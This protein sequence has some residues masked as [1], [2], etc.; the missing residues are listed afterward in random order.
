M[1]ILTRKPG[2]VI[3]IKVPAAAID[4]AAVDDNAK[5]VMIEITI[6]EIRGQQARVGVKAPKSVP[7][8]RLEIFQRKLTS[9]IDQHIDQQQEPEHSDRKAHDEHYDDI[10]DIDDE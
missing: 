10:F 9:V 4:S 2:E 5:P 7:V 6:L 8:D 1:L 3:V